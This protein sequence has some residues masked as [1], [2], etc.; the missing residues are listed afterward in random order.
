MDP[1]SRGE[2]Y[3]V[4]T[5]KG[6]YRKRSCEDRLGLIMMIITSS[7]VRWILFIQNILKDLVRALEKSS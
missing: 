1:E 6:R 2:I 5:Q 3:I 4:E 7:F